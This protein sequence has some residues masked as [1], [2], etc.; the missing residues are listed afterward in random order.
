MVHQKLLEFSVLF[1]A[2]SPRWKPHVSPPNGPLGT[3]SQSSWSE[4]SYPS[5]RL[6]L[7]TWVTKK[8]NVG[9]AG[10]TGWLP[11]LPSTKL[12]ASLHLKI[13]AWKTIRLPVGARHI[14]RRYVSFREG[15]WSPSWWA[16]KTIVLYMGSGFDPLK[17]SRGKISPQGKLFLSGHL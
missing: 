3:T 7:R 16:P 2:T 6:G 17:N 15:K 4:S 8:G 5:A 12:T 9:T 11:M 10:I 1:R 14:F 13:D